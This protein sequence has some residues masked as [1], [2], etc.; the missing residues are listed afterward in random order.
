[1]GLIHNHID[2]VYNGVSKQSTDLRLATQCEEM[3]NVIP[4]VDRGTRKRNP[5]EKITTPSNVTFNQFSH[6]YDKGLSGETEEK[7]SITIDDTNDIQVLDV[8]TGN[9]LPVTYEG[10]SLGYLSAGDP[11]SSYA[12][13]TVKDTT[14]VVNKD[15]VP[16]M[17]GEDIDASD[18]TY[19]YSDIN[20]TTGGASQYSVPTYAIKGR[21][22]LP[23]GRSFDYYVPTTYKTRSKL[24]PARHETYTLGYG[25]IYI[26]V[27]VITAQNEVV[28]GAVTTITVDGLTI[29]YTT[30]I[31]NDGYNTYP[32]SI[33]SYRSNLYGEVTKYLD[34][35]VYRVE[36]LSTAIRI[37]RIDLTQP[38]VSTLIT[39]P[40]SLGGTPPASKYAT[41]TTPSLGEYNNSTDTNIIS[42]VVNGSFLDSPALVTSD[43]DGTA[44]VWISKA[45]IDTAFPYSYTVT[46][47]ETS[48][49][50]IG[51]TTTA[52]ATTQ[53]AAS[54]IASWANG[55]ADFTASSSGSVVRIDRVSDNDYLIDV[56]DTFGNQASIAWKGSVTSLGDLPKSFP[57]INTIV[58][59]KGV[60]ESDSASYWVKY[61]GN[62]WVESRDPNR[63]FQ[64]DH[65]TMPHILV[66]N[67]DFTFTFKQFTYSELEVGDED[68]NSSPSFIGERIK[69][70]FFFKNRLGF[71]TSNSV[72]MS[73]IDDFGT[74][75]RTTVLALLD[76]DRIDFPVDSE[77]SIGLEY[78]SY[79]QDSLILF[80]DKS[81]FR[82]IGTGVLTPKTVSASL[83]TSYEI[84]KSVRPISLG[85]SIF[86]ATKRGDFSAIYQ[87]SI[88]A[89]SQVAS[90]IDI[91][92]Q[93]PE[94]I[95][96]EIVSLEGS[97]SS[98]MLFIRSRENQTQLYCYKF[99]RSGNELVQSAWFK[100]GFNMEIAHIFM[101]ERV[102]YMFGERY[103]AS[104]A[105]DWILA[106]GFWAMDGVWRMDASW[107]MGATPKTPTF[108]KITLD[109][110]PLSASIFKDNGDTIVESTI[111]L[112]EW[113]LEAGGKRDIRGHLL[114]KTI[115]INSE[116]AS[117]F[118]LEVQDKTRTDSTRSIAAK[119]TINSKPYISGRAEN[120]RIQIKNSSELGFQI[121]AIS[122]EGNYNSRSKRF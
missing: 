87:Y 107:Q 12:A 76:D 109:P 86:F 57:F 90:A 103:A 88:N 68:T 63:A 119:Y 104:N 3:I 38:V 45:S 55:L 83:L 94:Y 117:D 8:D 7:Y 93:V 37:I 29:K 72:S 19:L 23:R 114:F 16:R 36:L 33:N 69:D 67:E 122:L 26:G 118:S 17:I 62:S 95:D 9:Y 47:K 85:D 73:R 39:Y 49:S 53:A 46:L 113:V 111:E 102:L 92:E 61:D 30:K 4:S 79:L 20:F 70:V 91:S 101:F 80:G 77:R 60:N 22:Y 108:E 14:F 48:G 52:S 71:M 96:Q 15:I 6:K 105:E 28:S 2:S 1:M 34:P 32:E 82:V 42:G 97:S 74:F 78:V 51:T 100:W 120:M 25:D 65:K 24:A 59:I 116:P 5:T 43:Y 44:F 27:G 50:V 98:N 58:Q 66:R 35:F 106:T 13:L 40:V 41:L 21:K 89:S 99:L 31:L 56:D 115:Q 84:N 18:V 75:F 81:Q 64:I 110:I 54:A 11:Q 121:N 112:S 10:D